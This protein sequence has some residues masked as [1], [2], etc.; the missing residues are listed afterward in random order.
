MS[1]ERSK[2]GENERTV[3]RDI[4]FAIP[5]SATSAIAPDF[6]CI[7]PVVQGLTRLSHC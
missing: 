7:V 2:P 5:Q 1:M 6:D 3:I 4:H